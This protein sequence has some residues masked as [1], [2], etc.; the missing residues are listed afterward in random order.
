LSLYGFGGFKQLGNIKGKAYI[1]N[2]IKVS[3]QSHK[4][5]KN[6][7]GGL[8]NFVFE[9]SITQSCVLKVVYLG[10]TIRVVDYRSIQI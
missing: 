8:K 5:E 6:H 3:N 10:S 2:H 9:K 1:L 7:L 4:K